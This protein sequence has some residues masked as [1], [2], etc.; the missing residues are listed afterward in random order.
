[1][2]TCTPLKAIIIACAVLGAAA[3]FGAVHATAEI[4]E[5]VTELPVQVTDIDGEAVRQTIKVTYWSDNARANSPFL[6]LN[7]GRAG[8]EDARIRLGRARFSD[9]A[10]YFVSMGFTVL[11]PT[12]VGY[13]VTGGPDV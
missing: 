9:N 3:V 13:G 12:R 11:I 6:I 8:R 1:M 4:V 7:H 10:R 2:A 5:D